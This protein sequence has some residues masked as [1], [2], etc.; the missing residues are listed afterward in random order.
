MCQLP[1]LVNLG[2]SMNASHQ[3]RYNKAPRVWPEN[4]SSCRIKRLDISDLIQQTVNLKKNE[5][6][7]DCR[8]NSSKDGGVANIERAWPSVVVRN[9]RRSPRRLQAMIGVRTPRG[10]RDRQ[11]PPPQL[12]SWRALYG[13]VR[14]AAVMGVMCKRRDRASPAVRRQRRRR[15]RRRLHASNTLSGGRAAAAATR[16]GF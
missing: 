12:F 5:S 3:G 8:G 13:K 6:R 10:L 4:A 11:A 16:T 1:C 15:R 2:R 9:S 7:R 14:R